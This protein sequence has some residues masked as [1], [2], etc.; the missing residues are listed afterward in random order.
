MSAGSFFI[1]LAGAAVVGFIALA[2]WAVRQ[3]LAFERD[4]RAN[5]WTPA[6]THREKMDARHRAALEEDGHG[7]D[8]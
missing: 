5:E 1:A 3:L 6:T 4:S 8:D 7:G 2:A